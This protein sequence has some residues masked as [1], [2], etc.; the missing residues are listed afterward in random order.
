MLIAYDIEN[1]WGKAT[2][3][4]FI[5]YKYNNAFNFDT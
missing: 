1:D 2:L 4:F 3:L 5:S